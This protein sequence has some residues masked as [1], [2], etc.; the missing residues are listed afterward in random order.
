MILG[1]NPLGKSKG[2]KQF[3]EQA[4]FICIKTRESV[5]CIAISDST[6]PLFKLMFFTNS[7]IKKGDFLKEMIL[8][9]IDGLLLS[10]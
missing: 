7:V 5:L 1:C 6:V 9:L 8:T 2:P 10:Q 4:I 3:A